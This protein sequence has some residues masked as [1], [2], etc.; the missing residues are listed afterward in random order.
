[1]NLFLHQIIIINYSI[2]NYNTD[3]MYNI[4]KTILP[5]LLN[6][7]ILLMLY[8]PSEGDRILQA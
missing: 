7:S 5:Q 3:N 1:M 8:G 4:D 6:S 2:L